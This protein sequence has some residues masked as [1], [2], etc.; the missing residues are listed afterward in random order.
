MAEI[1]W[2][3]LKNERLKKIRGVSFEEVLRFRFIGVQEHPKR[4]NQSILVF[5]RNGYI[6][7]VPFV[8]DGE[9]IFLK[10]L[11]QSRKHTRLYKKGEL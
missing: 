1:R 10:T 3:K 6:W 7:L 8:P 11:F 5:E 2:N 4:E 9:G